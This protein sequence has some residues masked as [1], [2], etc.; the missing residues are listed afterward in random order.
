MAVSIRVTQ[1]SI[2]ARVM[3]N[4]QHNLNETGRL[5]QQ[6]SSG[7]LIS[8]PSDSPTGTVSAMSLRGQLRTME[9]YN[10]NADDGMGWLGTLDNTLTSSL[11]HIRRARDLAIDGRNPVKS[12]SA[13]A[14]EALAAE[15]ENIREGLIE[16]ANT[17]YVDR[18][19]LGGTTAGSAAYT[20]AGTYA[21]VPTG[22]NARIERTISGADPVRVDVTGPEVFGA[23][24]SPAQL[25]EVLGR[26]ATALRN[27]DDAAL[28]T[29]MGH[30]DTAMGTVQ[31]QLANVGAKYNRVEQMKQT[32][33]DRMLSLTTQLS[34]VEDIDLPK[35]IME[36]QLQQTAYQA[37]LSTTAKVIQPSLVD[38]L[39]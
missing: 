33:S 9:Q 15:V 28:S 39:R 6:L 25:F 2:T 5:E 32:V 20:A 19:V 26:L 16:L 7:K 35:T 18:P 29:E 8:R 36:M 22:P 21:G 38:F 1:Q 11:S 27:G 30:L 37:A 34:D 31:T 23:D 17:R 4:L 10:R 12:G 3:R 14:R 24:G 13:Q